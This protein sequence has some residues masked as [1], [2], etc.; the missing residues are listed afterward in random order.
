[1]CAGEEV[2][3]TT[4]KFFVSVYEDKIIIQARLEGEGADE[5]KGYLLKE[6]YPGD[7]FAGISFEELKKHGRGVFILNQDGGYEWV[8]EKSRG[9]DF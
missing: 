4:G 1:M 6:L 8:E 5:A 7:S 2:N 9:D 3:S